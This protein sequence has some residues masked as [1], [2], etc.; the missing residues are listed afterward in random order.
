[1]KLLE[2]LNIG[3]GKARPAHILG[4]KPHK[5]MY[6]YRDEDGV[7]RWSDNAAPVSA[8]AICGDWFPYEPELEKCEACVLAD[9]MDEYF[10]GN[11]RSQDW[12]PL[13]MQ[14]F[15]GGAHLRNW[16]CTCK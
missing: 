12:E 7:A 6:A 10:E 4:Y 11:M 3:K 15:T 14:G 13:K 5:E 9:K 1:M 2:A 8:E 16:H